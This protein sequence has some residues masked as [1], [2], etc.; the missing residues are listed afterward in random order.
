MKQQNDTFEIAPIFPCPVYRAHR[1]SSLLV[2]EEESKDINDIIEGG[3]SKNE[4]NHY[5]TNS[6]IFN[7]KLKKL[8]E[9][10]EEHLKMYVKEIID[11]KEEIDF[12]ITQSW[13][14]VTNPGGSHHIHSHANSI[15]SGV[16]YI[17][18]V[19]DDKI[20]FYNP[21]AILKNRIEIKQKEYNYWNSDSW[22][23]P[24]ATNQLLLFPSWVAH[25]VAK[26][27]KQT[28]DR[29]SISFNTFAKGALGEKDTLNELILE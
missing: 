4:G 27:K 6:H 12:Y 28:T 10:C 8:K 15:I 5:S 1:D 7:T 2:K 16:F 3:I 24:V 21:N 11:P 22:F 25:S 20:Y 13:V 29:I 18:A 17:G 19:E 23:M 14:N 26:N 9:F